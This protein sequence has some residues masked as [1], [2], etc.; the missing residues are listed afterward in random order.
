M[1]APT[2][3]VY[4]RDLLGRIV[5][6]GDPADAQAFGA[7][8][9]TPEGSIAS[10]TLKASA[11][12]VVARSFTYDALGRLSR[13]AEPAATL[14]LSY[15]AGGGFGAEPF[16][17]GRIAAERIA[18]RRA[19]FAAGLSPP[20]DSTGTYAYDAYGR[21]TSA[22]GSGDVSAA[23]DANGNLA[24][25]AQGGTSRSYAYAGGTDK[26][27]SVTSAGT[28]ASYGHDGAGRVTNAGGTAIVRD[29]TSGQMRRATRS[30]QT[31]SVLRDKRGWAV[32]TVTASGSKRLT[33][34]EGTGAPLTDHEISGGGAAALTTVQLHGPEGRIGLW[35]GGV[36]LAVS[37]DHRGS[38][39]FLYGTAGQ[40]VICLSYLAYGAADTAA[41]A[42]GSPVASVRWRYTGQ[43]WSETLG[44]YDYGARLYDPALG[45]FLSPDP[46]G[47][48]PSPYMY[49][50]GDPIGAVDPD[51]RVVKWIISHV[52]GMYDGTRFI[53]VD[54]HKNVVGR[55]LVNTGVSVIKRFREYKL[56]RQ[57][58]DSFEEISMFGTYST[59][60]YIDLDDKT[61]RSYFENAIDSRRLPDGDLEKVKAIPPGGLIKRQVHLS[62]LRDEWAI[63][64]P[65][66]P[67]SALAKQVIDGNS[68]MVI[69]NLAV[70]VQTIRLNSGMIINNLPP[71][72]AVAPPAPRKQRLMPSQ[73]GP[74]AMPAAPLAPF[75]IPPG[76][77]KVPV[78]VVYRRPPPQ[79]QLS[80]LDNPAPK[81]GLGG[82]L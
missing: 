76:L 21:L 79:M 9:Y 4:R 37:K 60:Q 32:M 66:P 48:T 69:N 58:S 52:L 55:F 62:S 59:K 78:R 63:A 45:R 31:V 41:G 56:L 24:S 14:D 71:P 65:P 39:R 43:D 35:L 64:A 72:P 25:L 12:A 57:A 54:H 13:I 38:S 30:G 50:G 75:V 73:P 61:L 53:L 29:P 19:G 67:S 49:V 2:T 17:D 82:P 27:A 42:P 81:K 51:G 7:W 77:R 80:F 20:A 15:R 40:A 36:P 10:E 18:Y 47:E 6:A 26:L 70:G 28:S 11:G 22:R 68:G 33:L 16:A 34:R 46:G 74:V 44:L 8:T 5:S 3:I 23:Y 1:P